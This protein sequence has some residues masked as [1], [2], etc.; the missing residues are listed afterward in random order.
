MICVLNVIKFL[1]VLLINLCLKV[2]ALT[3]L[4]YR[5]E[6]LRFEDF[7]EIITELRDDLAKEVGPVKE[8]KASKLYEL[9]VANAGGHIKGADRDELHEDAEKKR[10][11]DQED[12]FGNFDASDDKEVV[13]LRLLK[14]SDEEQMRKLYDLLKRS[15]LVEDYY[16]K[17]MIFP[18]FM[19]HQKV[20]LSA[21]G[22]EIGGD[23]LFKRRVGFSGTPSSL[24]PVEMGKTR[25]QKGSDGL[26]LRVMT[27]PQ[28]VSCEIVAS[29]WSVTGLLKAIATQPYNTRFSALIDTGALITG[30]TNLEVARFL[31]AEGLDWC[32]GVVYLDDNDVKMVLVRAT[33]RDVLLSQCGISA[34]KLFALYDQIHT[35]GTDLPFLSTFN[36]RAVQTLGKDMVWRDYVQGAWRMRR[37]GRG[38]S[39]HLY[40]IPEVYQT[41]HRDL[42]LAG[43]T[44]LLPPAFEM[45]RKQESNLK[46]PRPTEGVLK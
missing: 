2:I 36:A 26:M 23:I 25:F 30:L 28:H 7:T 16:L 24:L 6:G 43:L 39:I 17:E 40:V 15:W 13:P 18:T 8:R 29:N 41:I 21:S 1:F 3:F 31:L 44:E 42:A 32:D 27:D 34:V 10:L 11:V 12:S 37:L 46:R 38:H 4:G 5:Y 9:W 35:T 20:K 45:D 14:K 33:G 19:R 22:Q